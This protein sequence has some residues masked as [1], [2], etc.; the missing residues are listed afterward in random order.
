[1]PGEYIDQGVVKPVQESVQFTSVSSFTEASLGDLVNKPDNMKN[2]KVKGLKKS[3]L[4]STMQTI[5]ETELEEES[6][7]N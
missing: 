6:Q 5:K 3:R 1:M 7:S 2:N 4:K